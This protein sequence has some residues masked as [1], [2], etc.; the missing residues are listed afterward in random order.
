MYNKP[1]VKTMIAITMTGALI[2][3]GFIVFTMIII[4][5]VVVKR[6]KLKGLDIIMCD[7]I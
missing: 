6:M 4:S 3:V 2:V 1:G 7:P 5:V